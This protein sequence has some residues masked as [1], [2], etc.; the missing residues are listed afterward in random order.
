MALSSEPVKSRALHR[1]E[2][3]P[4]NASTQEDT[5]PGEEEV[6]HARLRKV[7]HTRRSHPFHHLEIED[8]EEAAYQLLLGRRDVL[9]EAMTGLDQVQPLESGSLR[10]H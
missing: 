4:R 8:V 2:P 7:E 6:A 10:I 9:P 5:I 3:W 1:C